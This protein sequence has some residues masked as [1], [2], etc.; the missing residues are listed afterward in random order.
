[1]SYRTINGLMRHLRVKGISINGSIQKRK[2]RNV[3]YYHGY[4]GYRFFE[5]ATCRIPFVSFDE[6]FA[7]IQ[8]DSKLKALL[9]ERVMF[10]ETAVKNVA[11]ES[12]LEYVKSENIQDMYNR[13]IS[14]Y[15]NAGM[16]MTAKQK[17]DLQLKKLNLE[18]MIQHNLTKAYRA[19]NPV[20]SHFYNNVGHSDVPIWALFEIFT[21]GDFGFLL[22]CMKYDIRDDISKRLGLNVAADTNRELVYR[23]IYALKDLRNAIAHNSVI[24][25]ARFRKSNPSKAMEKCLVQEIGL[26]YINFKTIGDYIILICYYLKLLGVRASEIKAFVREYLKLTNFYKRSVSASVSGIVIHRDLVARMNKL[27]NYL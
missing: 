17:K 23:Y 10:I 11:L 20:I 9:Y 16:Q 1:M 8:Y 4:K 27:V 14:S 12:I 22:S 25:D 26:N 3:G 13:A 19:D 2:L 24:F 21:M 6:L 5:N 18:T 15:K 7:T